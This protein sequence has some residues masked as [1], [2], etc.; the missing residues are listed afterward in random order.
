M[1]LEFL[2]SIIKAS[3]EMRA[4][5]NMIA[6]IPAQQVTKVVRPQGI[7]LQFFNE[8]IKSATLNHQLISGNGPGIYSNGK[9]LQT[10]HEL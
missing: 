9:W 5:R 7:N 3:Q 4:Y 10:S 6:G 8:T 2:V 1:F